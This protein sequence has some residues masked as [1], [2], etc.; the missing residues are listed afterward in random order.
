MGIIGA[1]A[2]GAVGGGKIKV[3]KK[4]FSAAY[5]RSKAVKQA[6]EQERALVKHHPNL[7]GDPDNIRFVTYK[8]HYRLHNNGK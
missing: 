6:W 7:A 3:A 8:E 1:A 4:A 5:I 2:I